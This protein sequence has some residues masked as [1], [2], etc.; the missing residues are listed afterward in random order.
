MFLVILFKTLIFAAGDE[1]EGVPCAEHHVKIP[2]HCESGRLL[3]SLEYVGQTFQISASA[4]PSSRHF[5]VLANGDVICAAASGPS[6]V[7]TVSFGVECRL[8]LLAWTELI[9]VTVAD[10]RDV[11]LSFAQP[12]FEGWVVENAQAQSVVSGLQN[13]SVSVSNFLGRVLV[14]VDPG[15]AESSVAELSIEEIQSRSTLRVQFSISAGPEYMF[16][17]VDNG[18]GSEIHV[19]DDEVSGRFQSTSWT[20]DKTLWSTRPSSCTE[21]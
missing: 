11:L 17:L 5:A 19:D 9:H 3:L 6:T 16:Y 2:R 15:R 7:G 13:M 21:A 18:E 12:Y 20:T 8:G 4:G 1:V 10:D 14:E